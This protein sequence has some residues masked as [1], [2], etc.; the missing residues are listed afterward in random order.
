MFE[1]LSFHSIAQGIARTLRCRGWRFSGGV[2]FIAGFIVLLAGCPNALA[3]QVKLLALGTSLTS[4]P[5]LPYDQGFTAKLEKALQAKGQDVLVIDGGAPDETTQGAR[6]RLDWVLAEPV[7][8]VIVELGIND[9]Q[10]GRDVDDIEFDLGGI[11]RSLRMRKI[12]TLLTGMRAPESLGEDYGTKFADMYPRLAV[13][14]DTL[15]YPYFLD[16][17]AG[18]PQL[19]Q[20]DGIHPNAQG[21][22]TIVSAM[23]PAV[24]HLLSTIATAKGH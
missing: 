19:L 9:A 7:D 23:L 3:D 8:G 16:G 6:A 2:L 24:E 13:D 21:V 15:F 17:V 10:H 12:P 22:D 11:L 18:N 20:G 1:G 4:C 5:E 14:Y